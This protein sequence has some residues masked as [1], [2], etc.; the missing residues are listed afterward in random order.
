[1]T[2]PRL[3]HT[4][5]ALLGLFI[6]LIQTDIS[7]GAPRSVSVTIGAAVGN[8]G[9]EVEVPLTLETGGLAETMVLFVDYDPALV[10]PAQQFYEFVQT[11]QAG[12]PIRDEDGNV[13]ATR[14]AV[15]PESSVTDAGKLIQSTVHGE[16]Y[17]S[18]AIVGIDTSTL[19]AGPLCTVA[20]EIRPGVSELDSILLDGDDVSSSAAATSADSEIPLDIAVDFADGGI[21]TGCDRPEAP[22]GVWATSNRNDGVKVTWIAIADEDAEYRVYRNTQLDIASAV[23]LGEAWQTEASFF[24]LTALTREVVPDPGCPRRPIVS[25][26]TYYWVRARNAEGC[27]S[28]FSAA[29]ATGGRVQ[30]KS[31]G[32]P[33]AAGFGG[34]ANGT[35][36]MYLGLAAAL[37][38]ARH[39]QRRSH[40]MGFPLPTAE[41]LRK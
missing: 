35:T 5:S 6:L 38:A 24:D 28:E 11:D 31:G 10:R 34:G 4:A 13:V 7:A 36:A 21:A 25:N 16:G 27:I 40:R 12:D 18:I 14:S 20:F 3:V 15:R 19:A 2:S 17:I 8:A 37:F 30:A 39:R 23:P 26:I 32:A 29:P 9:D 22:E 41:S 33:A 1:M